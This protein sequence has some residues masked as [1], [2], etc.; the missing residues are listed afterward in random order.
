MSRQPFGIEQDEIAGC[1][2]RHTL[3]DLEDS[4]RYVGRIDRQ[5]DRAWKRNVPRRRDGVDFCRRVD[6]R[7]VNRRVVE[8]LVRAGAF[9]SVDPRRS[10]LL[11]SV[12][13]ALEAA[14][15]AER[16]AG[17][18]A[19]VGAAGPDGTEAGDL[20]ELGRDQPR[21]RDGVAGEQ[22]RAPGQ[23][24]IADGGRAGGGVARD[25]GGCGM[26]TEEQR[27][28]PQFEHLPAMLRVVAINLSMGSS[29]FA[30]G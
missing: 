21:E 16:A 30:S 28:C 18:F 9:D 24:G 12:G 26:A 25:L 27:G 7:M 29:P 20:V 15:Q 19:H 17:D 10:R 23:L 13:R 11:A 4:A 2:N 8:A 6:K 22:G 5:L 1:G 3:M 14:E